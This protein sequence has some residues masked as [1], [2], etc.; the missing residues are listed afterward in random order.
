MIVLE[1]A[2]HGHTTSLIDISPYK[3]AGPGGAC[4]PDWVHAAP[5][6][7]VYRGA[8]KATDADAGEKYAG[9]V[10]KIIAN[11]RRCGRG[12]GGF[13]A[14]SLPSVGRQIVFPP[15]YLDAV[16]RAVHAAGGVRIADE[17][18][19]GFGRIGTHFWGFEPQRVVPDIVVLG[20]P[21]GNGHPIG[22]VVTRRRLRTRSTTAWSSS[23]RSGATQ[24]RAPSAWLCWTCCAMRACRRTR[25]GW[26]N[27]CWQGCAG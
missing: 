5:I 11:L 4:A 15:G 17:V 12:L 6:P 1:A 8:Y 26:A 22:A 21:I 18:Q 14:E 3:H 7:D 23:A 19:T 24:S 16:Y 13:I 25:Y 9:H 2:Y 10:A 27:G 20:K